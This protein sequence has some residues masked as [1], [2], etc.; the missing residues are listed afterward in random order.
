MARARIELATHSPLWDI[1]NCIM[2]PSIASYPESEEHVA[3][4][5]FRK[6]LCVFAVGKVNEMENPI[7]F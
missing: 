1:P 5:I 2:T 3:F 7:T 4:H 6:N